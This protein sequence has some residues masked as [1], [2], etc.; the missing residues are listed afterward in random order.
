MYH[1]ASIFFYN[2]DFDFV[3]FCRYVLNVSCYSG[4]YHIM[5]NTKVMRG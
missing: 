2:T 1:T 4:I 5:R 3:D